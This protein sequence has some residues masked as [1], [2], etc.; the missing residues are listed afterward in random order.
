LLRPSADL[1]SPRVALSRDHCFDAVHRRLRPKPAL[2]LES[3]REPR[4]L[5]KSATSP[6]EISS[7]SMPIRERTE[8]FICRFR[9]CRLR[10]LGLP[11]HLCDILIDNPSR[12]IDSPRYCTRPL[13]SPAGSLAP[14]ADRDTCSRKRTEPRPGPYWYNLA[15]RLVRSIG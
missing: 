6:G 11:R 1:Q 10:A 8:T 9:R 15:R 5:S 7:T 13:L 3:E 12:P 14:A 2:Q 4:L